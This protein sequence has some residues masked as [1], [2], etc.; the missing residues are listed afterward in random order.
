M[1]KSI[2]VYSVL[3]SFYVYLAFVRQWR[4][5]SPHVCVCCHVG[6]CTNKAE[7]CPPVSSNKESK[8][9]EEGGQRNRRSRVP[10][11]SLPW[12]DCARIKFYNKNKQQEMCRPT[13]SPPTSCVSFS[14]LPVSSF[15][16]PSFLTFCFPSFFCSLST[17]ETW[18][19]QPITPQMMMPLQA[20]WINLSLNDL[21][22]LWL[23][24]PHIVWQKCDRYCAASTL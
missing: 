2:Y 10:C 22:M 3:A 15:P 23:L 18:C 13:S 19:N 5:A 21:I 16:S 14:P 1:P 11:V 17:A 24:T 12:L 9:R 8:D 4:C 6:G 20:V 7:V